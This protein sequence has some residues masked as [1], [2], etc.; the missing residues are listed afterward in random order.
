M[1]VAKAYVSL[2]SN[3]GDRLG[4][5]RRAVAMLG[6]HEAIEVLRT[7]SVYETDPV[8]YVDQ[9][10]FLN[11]VAEIET[12]L[13]PHELLDA[14]QAIEAAL[15]RVRTVRW[16]PRTIDLDIALIDDLA[17]DDERLTV[18]HPRMAERAFVLVPLAEIAPGAR[19]AG[20]PVS[21]LAA[22]VSEDPAQGV[23]LFARAGEWLSPQG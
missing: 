13:S 14:C 17:I 21:A 7:S 3:V 5:L 19:C 4:F 2:G 8:G 20:V 11:A 16:G 15:G 9:P 23:R 6:E 22:K 1:T 12:S 18:P 10:P